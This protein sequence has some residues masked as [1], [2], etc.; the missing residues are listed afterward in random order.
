MFCVSGFVN[1]QKC[2][3]KVDTGA[4]VTLIRRNFLRGLK[5]VPLAGSITLKY[6]TGEKVPVENKIE[7]LVKIGD[8]AERICAYEVDME[9]ECL[10][11]T[12]FLLKVKFN[13]I[14]DSFFKSSVSHKKKL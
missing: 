3:F 8:F 7:V 5:R 14:L 12:D 2:V 6:P 13:T 10:L 1:G 9:E 11:G 4:D